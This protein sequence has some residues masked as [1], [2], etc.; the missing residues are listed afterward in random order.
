MPGI[1]KM[2]GTEVPMDV[3]INLKEFRDVHSDEDGLLKARATLN[4]KFLVEQKDAAPILAADMELINTHGT[5][6]VTL[7]GNDLDFEIKGFNFT[8]IEANYV[9]FG[10]TYNQFLIDALNVLFDP[11][12]YLLPYINTFLKTLPVFSL[13]TEIAGIFKLTEMTL[14]WGNDFALIGATPI[15]I[16]PNETSIFYTAPQTTTLLERLYESDT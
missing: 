4:M 10:I 16:K 1:S 7:S 2:Y 13:P 5:F 8:E 6:N 11:R 14:E 12:G 3:V 9:T 15:F